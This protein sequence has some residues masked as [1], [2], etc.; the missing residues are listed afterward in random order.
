MKNEEDL[1]VPDETAPDRIVSEENPEHVHILHGVL[2][3]LKTPEGGPETEQE[4]KTRH[5]LNDVVHRMLILGL[6][7]STV[8]LFAGL[9]LSAIYHRPLP[10]KVSGFREMLEGLKTGS[11]PSILSLGILLL[12]A[13]PVFRVVGSLVE[14]LIKRDWRYALITFSVLVILAASVFVGG[15]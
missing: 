15:G 8:V 14:F 6:I 4:V 9:A 5:E 12:I 11:P 2:G 1:P 3:L 10:T 7:L 13:T